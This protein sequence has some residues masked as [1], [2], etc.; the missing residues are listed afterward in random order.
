MIQII[1][2]ALYLID[3]LMRLRVKSKN[4]FRSQDMM[5]GLEIRW[6][7]CQ[8]GAYWLFS[9]T[10]VFF[11]FL[12]RLFLTHVMCPLYRWSRSVA[13]YRGFFCYCI[14]L[15][16]A[17]SYHCYKTLGLFVFMLENWHIITWKLSFIQSF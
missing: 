2:D 15:R 16:H 4:L 12:L 6:N 7:S 10:I 3:W 14:N 5:M 11:N 8:L 9:E 1:E 13:F 17:S